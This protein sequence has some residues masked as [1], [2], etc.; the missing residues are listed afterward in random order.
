M[1]ENAKP[2][3]FSL[4]PGEK[5]L[6]EAT[7]SKTGAIALFVLVACP[8]LL[9]GWAS[10]SVGRTPALGAGLIFIGLGL[11]VGALPF[12]SQERRRVLLTTRR[13]IFVR[14]LTNTVHSVPLLGIED[15][16]LSTSDVT[17]R[18]GA[19]QSLVLRV[20]QPELLSLAIEMARPTGDQPS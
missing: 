11:V 10:V 19:S 18:S 9:I 13:V 3:F 4:V 2:K 20:D 14:G 5:I 1:S 12:M 7:W 16:V 8:L 6:H 15:V 17:I